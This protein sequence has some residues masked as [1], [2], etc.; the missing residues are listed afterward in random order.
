MNNYI[1]TNWTQ[2]MNKFLEIYH[3]PILNHEEKENLN[4]SINNLST[5]KSSE[6]DGFTAKFYQTFK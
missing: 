1:P 2:E 5:N 3:L 6:P 4:Q